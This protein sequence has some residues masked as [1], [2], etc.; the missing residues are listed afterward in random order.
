MPP[1]LLALDGLAADRPVVVMGGGPSLVGQ[2]MQVRAWSRRVGLGELAALVSVNDYAARVVGADVVVSVD[3]TKTRDN[4]H[5]PPGAVF[6]SPTDPSADVVPGPGE[7]WEIMT[8]LTAVRVAE[9]MTTGVVIL[10]GFDLYSSGGHYCTGQHRP[11][12]DEWIAA[13]SPHGLEG[14]LRV[15]SSLADLALVPGRI[16]AAGGPLIDGG[17]VKGLAG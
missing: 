15:W 4:Q 5:I 2:L 12:I 6:V 8:A 13:G 7:W 3:A 1:D 16:F 11:E 9:R 14:Q 17:I 10:A